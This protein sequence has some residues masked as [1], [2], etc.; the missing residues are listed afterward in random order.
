MSPFDLAFV[1]RQFPAFGEPSLQGFAHFENAGGS[2]AC[3][4]AI[5]A[6]ERFY[7]RNKVQPYHHFA[8]SS[9][10]GEQM[11]RAYERMAAWLNVGADEV[12]FGPST[13]LNTYVLAQALRQELG[14]VLRKKIIPANDVAGFIGNGH[15]MR[16]GLHAIAEADRFIQTME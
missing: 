10:G 15:F 5:D 6:L 3:G 9:E 4:Q 12:H 11:D 7:R 13:S 1:R 8:P 14:R 2:Y 16:D